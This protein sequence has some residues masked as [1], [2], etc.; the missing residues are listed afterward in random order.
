M[1]EALAWISW[2]AP[3]CTWQCAGAPGHG[4]VLPRTPPADLGPKVPDASVDELRPGS[5]RAHGSP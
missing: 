2:A 4:Q 1:I 3:G 5:H